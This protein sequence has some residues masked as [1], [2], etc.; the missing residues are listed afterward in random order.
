MNENASD[1]AIDNWLHLDESVKGIKMISR[2]LI[3]FEVEIAIL[4]SIRISKAAVN[5]RDSHRD[6]SFPK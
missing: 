2:E 5:G 3:V 4:I 6:R 1:R